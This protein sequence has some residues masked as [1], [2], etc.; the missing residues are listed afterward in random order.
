VYINF[1]YAIYS[2]DEPD[3]T[4]SST[5]GPS[6]TSTSSI[7]GATG[8]P[9]TTA[10]HNSSSNNKMGI[11]VGCV[12]G[13]LAL[14]AVVVVLIFLRR[15]RSKPQRST[16]LTET[17]IVTLG[18]LQPPTGYRDDISM[19]H[20]PLSLGSIYNGNTGSETLY[21]SN[22]IRSPSSDLARQSPTLV[23]FRRE[24]QSSQF[25]SSAKS[26][27]ELHMRPPESHQRLPSAQ[28]EL[29]DLQSM[30][31]SLGGGS[32]SS[33]I[34]RPERDQELDTIRE[35]IRLLS[36]RMEHLQVDHSDWGRSNRASEPPPP[37]YD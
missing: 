16:V 7:T 9:V 1:D 24:Y 32:S 12:L 19:I 29:H 28:Q 10:A 33:D 2:A 6:S 30:Y 14:V 20:S 25:T 8:T 34:R 31:S 22:H 21:E 27:E 11:I 4:T 23:P 37:A 13:G 18:G 35:Q 17:S 15:G 36:S 5:S 26:R 3:N